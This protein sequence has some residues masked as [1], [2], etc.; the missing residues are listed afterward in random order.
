MIKSS[1]YKYYDKIFDLILSVPV[2]F[3][4]SGIVLL[5]ILILGIVLNYW[6]RTGLSDWLS[7]LLSDERV[8]VAMQAGSRSVFLVTALSAVASILLTLLL[9]LVLTKPLLELTQVAQRVANG[10]LLPRARVWSKDEIGEVAH[11]VNL[12][13]DHLVNSQ[14][15]L[16]RTNRR[17]EAVNR[18]AM[19]AGREMNLQNVLDAALY[20]TLDVM[21]LSAG[22][23]YLRDQT[24][25]GDALFR[26]SSAVGLRP[27][28]M[29]KLETGSGNKCRCQYELLASK[30][31]SGASFKQCQRIRD[32]DNVKHSYVYHITIPL[33]A[34]DQRFGIIN[35]LCRHGKSPSSSDMEML[36]TIGAQV[37]EFIANARLRS[38]L[39]EKE[40]AR[41]ALL[42][43]LVKAQEDE[44]A[45]LSRELHDG[46]GQRL[47]SL[48]VRLKTME[49]RS[50]SDEFRYK[51]SELCQATSETIEEVR[52]ISHRL[53]P[54]ELE[55]FGLDVAL[56]AL[57]LEMLTDTGLSFDC[58]I[59]MVGQRLP[60][61]VETNLYRV[62]QE[63][64]TNIV[65]HANASH[66]FIE[67]NIQQNVLCLRVEDDGQGFNFED[68]NTS[69]GYRR[70]G[71]TGMRE[72]VEM[73]GG[74]L[75]V[76]SDLGAGTSIQIK[77][78][79]QLEA[80]Q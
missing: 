12:M 1:L 45:R 35:M 28:E 63:C 55:E 34:R 24:N 72:R 71:L 25:N 56:R 32:P 7:Y 65:R 48:L 30:Y 67:L 33:E 27:E 5:P 80:N 70:L 19:V 46:I 62:V 14:R 41:Q 16:E 11:S 78:P 51:V 6:V 73:L 76:K 66:V 64:L 43:A 3:K 17:L 58:Q 50:P 4:I 44:R 53:R 10:D 54:P 74:S 75:T 22:W 40:A 21:R 9:M 8:N 13:I 42:N 57:A 59:N 49:S 47:T 60:F 52:G 38:R 18:V 26:L 69:D 2:R 20:T 31:N 61:E 29:A 23:I 77:V 68:I 15:K 36:T 37:S 79:L 39:A